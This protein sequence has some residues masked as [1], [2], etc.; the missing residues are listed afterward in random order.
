MGN[1]ATAYMNIDE[2]LARVRGN[3]K[4]YKRML[5][6]FLQSAELPALEEAFAAQDYPRAAE[7]AHAIKGMTGNLSLTCLFD[8]SVQLMGQLREGAPD[9]VA[10]ELYHDALEKT[11]EC[12]TNAIETMED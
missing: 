11:R 5:Q 7:L 8:I 3:K 6:M 12:V 2:A 1:D 4:L 10:V 9:P